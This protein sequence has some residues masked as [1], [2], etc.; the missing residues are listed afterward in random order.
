MSTENV[1]LAW[2]GN[3]SLVPVTQFYCNAYFMHNLWQLALLHNTFCAFQ[4]YLCLN[5][6][7]R[8]TFVTLS[9][10]CMCLKIY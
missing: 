5:L 10:L 9:Y 3:N 2:N 4:Y 8:I 1:F 6:L 7:Q